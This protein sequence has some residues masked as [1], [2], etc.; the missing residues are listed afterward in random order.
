MRVLRL[1]TYP[2]EVASQLNRVREA[3]QAHE[4]KA[5]YPL[6]TLLAALGIF[7]GFAGMLAFMAFGRP[8]PQYF[9]PLIGLGFL[10]ATIHT[11]MLH[12]YH[13]ADAE[14]LRYEVPRF[15]LER[16]P[17]VQGQK[18]SLE[19]DF[20]SLPKGKLRWLEAQFP[21]ARGPLH[22]GIERQFRPDSHWESSSHG[23]GVEMH[24]QK[25]LEIQDIIDLRGTCLSS[26]NLER[27]GELTARLD[28]LGWPA[29]EIQQQG[30]SL[31]ILAPTL[32]LR[33]QPMFGHQP[34]A[35]ELENYQKGVQLLLDSLLQQA[36]PPAPPQ[37]TSEP[38]RPDSEEVSSLFEFDE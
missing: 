30:E 19:L 16:L 17:L 7:P 24:Y 21:L 33:Y 10:L 23:G 20:R 4:A 26:W 34:L 12:F 1:H 27:A 31:H 14:N 6:M 36:A 25:T 29:P 5:G 15:L 13:R 22:I 32:A 3:D 8:A 18:M 38:S 35:F 9:V 37:A 2:D 11:V 28:D